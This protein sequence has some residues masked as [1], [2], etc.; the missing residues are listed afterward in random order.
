MQQEITLSYFVKIWALCKETKQQR[1]KIS[2][3]KLT[4][5][6]FIYKKKQTTWKQN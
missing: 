4:N 3:D 6:K 5:Y 1:T 2:T